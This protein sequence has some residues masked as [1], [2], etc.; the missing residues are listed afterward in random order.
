MREHMS[1]T[2]HSV[3]REDPITDA[4]EL[5]ML[6]GVRHLPVLE[7]GKLVG[8]VSLADLYAVEAVMELDPDETEVGQAM[9]QDVYSVG[10]DTLLADVAAH[11]AKEHIGSVVIVKQGEL[12]GV[13]TA[14]DACRV[15]ATLLNPA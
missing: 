4:K 7:Q 2:C 1:K 8:M 12:L 13:F 14:S 10:P 11:M 9:S 3:A 5:M 6:H 15:L